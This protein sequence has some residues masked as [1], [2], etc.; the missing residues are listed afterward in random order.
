VAPTALTEDIARVQFRERFC[1]DVATK[2]EE[3][4]YDGGSVPSDRP[5]Y[6]AIGEWVPYWVSVVLTIDG[7][8]HL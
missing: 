1:A 2:E 3:L 8:R 5:S 7:E 6:S 4:F